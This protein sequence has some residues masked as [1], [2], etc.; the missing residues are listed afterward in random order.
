MIAFGTLQILLS[1]T[2]NFHKL[3]WIS[4]VAATTS[5]GYV[6]I[7][8]VLCLSVVISG[9]GVS[10]E[11]IKV[12]RILSSMGNID[13]ACTY[14]TVIYDILDT[15]KSHPPEN[16]QMKKANVIGV[17]TMTIIFL[18]C[19]CLDYAAFGDHPPGSIFVGFY[20]PFWLVAMGDV[21]IV[22]NMIGAYQM[23]AQPI[24]R[25]IKW[26]LISCGLNWIS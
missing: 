16:K 2:L 20:E 8:I 14:A 9:K 4:T 19:S 23:M 25:V 11:Y 3:T 1:E 12:W 13:L 10:T 22:I 15:L 21:F 5:F 26:M 7:A 24:F 18:L 17:S 6:F